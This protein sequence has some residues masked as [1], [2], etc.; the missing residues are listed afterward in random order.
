MRFLT[1]ARSLAL[2]VL[3]VGLAAAPA[4][5]APGKFHSLSPHL[6]DAVDLGRAPK[7][8]GCGTSALRDRLR[9]A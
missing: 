2:I 4:N 1:I 3:T 7:Q 9:G 8:R 5:A 6:K